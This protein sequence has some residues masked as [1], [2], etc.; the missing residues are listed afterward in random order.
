MTYPDG[1]T[2]EGAPDAAGFPY[3]GPDFPAHTPETEQT[4]RMLA[5]S[6][7]VTYSP[8]V[9]FALGRIRLQKTGFADIPQL[10]VPVYVARR[11]TGALVPVARAA[12]FAYLAERGVA[13]THLRHIPGV[14]VGR[15]RRYI[16]TEGKTRMGEDCEYRFDLSH[17]LTAAVD[18]DGR[19]GT[20]KAGWELAD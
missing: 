18:W 4:V 14:S 7:A 11:H 3:T 17:T 6:L 15:R 2:P 12:A 20:L 19:V 8:G 13:D 16:D 9:P 1:M 5:R 10:A